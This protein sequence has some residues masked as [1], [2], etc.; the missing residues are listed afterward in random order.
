MARR[1]TPLVDQG[2]RIYAICG[3]TYAWVRDLD[4]GGGRGKRGYG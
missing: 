4:K 3:G 2:L 1:S